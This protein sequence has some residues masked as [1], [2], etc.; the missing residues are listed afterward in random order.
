[1]QRLT[2]MSQL[3]AS[4]DSGRLYFPN[5]DHGRW[6]V[7]KETAFQG[8]RHPV[9]DRLVWTYDLLRNEAAYQSEIKRPE[10]RA[11]VTKWKREFVSEVQ[12]EVDPR[13]RVRFLT[14]GSR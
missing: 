9:L 14:G 12:S 11:R 5:S 3:S 6:G 4:V 7:E 1:M 8:L 10:L 13:R 2:T